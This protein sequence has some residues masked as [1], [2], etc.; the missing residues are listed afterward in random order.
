MRTKL[1]LFAIFNVMIFSFFSCSDNVQANFTYSPTTPRCGQVVSFENVTTGDSDWEVESWTW[2]FGDDGKSTIKSPTHIYKEPGIYTVKLMVD[3]NKHFVRSLNITVVDSIPTI[4]KNVD[5]VKYYQP[6]K[7]SLL[8]YNPNSLTITYEWTFSSNAVGNLTNGKSTAKEVEVYFNKKNVYEYISLHLIMGTELD[9]IIKDTVFVNDV[10]SKSLL[11][12][13]MNGKI[14]R[15][16]IIE[17]GQEDYSMLDI[18]S[19]KHPFNMSA[20]SNQLYI[21]DAGS[22]VKYK[23]NW[24]TDTKGDGN[25]RVVNLATNTATEIIHNRGLSSHFGFFN[26]YVDNTNIY[27]TDFSEFIYKIAKNTTIGA[28]NWKGSINNQDSVPYYLVKSKRLGYYNHGIEQNQ[29]SGGF[30]FYDQAYFWAKGGT[31]RG[32]YRFYPNDILKADVN[33]GTAV[34]ALGA[35]LS[36]YAIRAFVIDKIN[37]RIYFSATAPADKIGLW[38]SNMSGTNVQLIDNAPMD[39]ESKYITG[40]VVDNESNKLYWAYRSP[41]TVGAN[42]PAGTWQS[43]YN[44]NPTHR[45]G[46]KRASLATQYKPVGAIEYFALGVASYGIALDEVKK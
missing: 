43:Y 2:T 14:L 26:A 37:Q 18:E 12:S 32:I 6:A 41:E 20:T 31:G 40:I 9:T 42:A 10:K 4:Y 35:I 25:I 19:G 5:S 38:V 46:I 45:T 1:L 44:T 16:R 39:D 34:P 13:Q 24:L 23:S 30:A 8:V 21:F 27:W 17:N 15:Q 33:S 7:F 11:M 36:N 3:S 29:P 28:F 22:D